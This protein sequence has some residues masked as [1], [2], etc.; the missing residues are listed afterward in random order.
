MTLSSISWAGLM[1]QFAWVAVCSLA[2][3][4]NYPIA[5]A[6]LGLAGWSIMIYASRLNLEAIEKS[7]AKR[8]LWDMLMEPQPMHS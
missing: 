3:D 4:H 5:A 1:V 8:I 6:I 7:R 2:A